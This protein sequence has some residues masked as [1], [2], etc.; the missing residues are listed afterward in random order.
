MRRKSTEA[1]TREISMLTETDSNSDDSVKIRQYLPEDWPE[2][3][4]V[5]DRARPDEL[6]GSC[7]P[8]AFVRLADEKEDAANFQRSRK[9][10][11]CLG[12]RIVGFVGVD[13]TFLSWL[14]VDPDYYGRGIGRQLLRLGMELI[15][16]SAWTVVLS[17]NVRAQRLYQ[18]EGFQIVQTFDGD[19][20]G[21]PCK[22]F[23]LA[24]SPGESPAAPSEATRS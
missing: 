13:Y 19:N 8:R 6:H 3:C 1:E 22:C 5:H 20:A 24:L 2:V 18:S 17:G 14:Y 23:K 16:P 11:A 9:F 15:G 4:A 21:Y 10:V 12:E 7:D